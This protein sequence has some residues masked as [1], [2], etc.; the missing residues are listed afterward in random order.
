MKN[1]RKEYQKE[2]TATVSIAGEKVISFRNG[3]V[4]T[5]VWEKKCQGGSVRFSVDSIFDLN[6]HDV[7]IESE[8]SYI[9]YASIKDAMRG[10]NSAHQWIAAKQ[11]RSGLAE[12]LIG[13]FW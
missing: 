13:L 12:W 8:R 6:P 1:W 11:T 7:W 4:V 10:F 5:R 9:P 2:Q 3:K